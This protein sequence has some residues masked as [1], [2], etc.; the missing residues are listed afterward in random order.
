MNTTTEKT[1][2]DLSTFAARLRAVA[3]GHIVRATYADG[4]WADTR[5]D[6]EA[7]VSRFF[8]SG[9]WRP[10]NDTY[11]E[12]NAR[13][14]ATYSVVEPGPKPADEMT[15]DEMWAE[16]GRYAGHERMSTLRRLVTEKREREARE[17]RDAE[18]DA[19]TL[20]ELR[21]R[22]WPEHEVLW[23]ERLGVS[24]ADWVASLGGRP[25]VVQTYGAT[26]DE[27]RESLRVCIAALAKRKE[28]L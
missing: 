5:L 21:D 14:P 2:I 25:D 18:I 13:L 20:P 16:L 26:R 24:A 28:R 10:E 12:D 6:E 15:G 23:Y 9:E 19:M 7:L 4:S 8:H 22:W 3:D 27:A 1:E 11:L 17:A